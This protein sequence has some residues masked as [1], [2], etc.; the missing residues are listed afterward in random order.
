LAKSRHHGSSPEVTL[1]QMIA[2]TAVAGCNAKLK[3]LDGKCFSVTV[4]EVDEP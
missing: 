4:K 2:Q 1:K 3:N